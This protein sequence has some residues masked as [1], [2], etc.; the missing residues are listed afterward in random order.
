MESSPESSVH[1]GTIHSVKGLEYDSVAVAN[2]NGNAFK[3]KNEENENL[4][5]TACTRAR[6]T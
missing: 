2:V 1:V 3:I 4:L 6:K 5:Y